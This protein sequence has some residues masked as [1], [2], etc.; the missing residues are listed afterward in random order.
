MR[1]RPSPGSASAPCATLQRQARGPARAAGVRP[2]SART[3]PRAFCP[4]TGQGDGSAGPFGCRVGRLAGKLPGRA[5][6]CP[7]RLQQACGD[8]Q[9]PTVGSS[10]NRTAGRLREGRAEGRSVP[11]FRTMLFVRRHPGPL[12]RGRAPGRV[13]ALGVRARLAV[14]S[15]RVDGAHRGP[16]SRRRVQ[17]SLSEKGDRLLSE[18]PHRTLDWLTTRLATATPDRLARIEAA[19]REHRSALEGPP[20]G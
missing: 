10:G 17:L 1:V 7:A 18:A 19:L 4:V 5:S 6:Q 12:E 13:D 15:R 3:L 9:R 8:G 20:E 11:Q 16:A 14:G 2:T